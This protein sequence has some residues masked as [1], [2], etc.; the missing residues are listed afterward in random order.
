MSDIF[1]ILFS[2]VSFGKLFLN[3]YSVNQSVVFAIVHK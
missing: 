3:F 2:R 1:I